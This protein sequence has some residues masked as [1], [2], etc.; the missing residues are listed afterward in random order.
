VEEI[1][2]GTPFELIAIDIMEAV[3]TLGEVIGVT[4]KED[5]IDQIFSRFCIGK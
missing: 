4:V 3:D 1:R 5:V 2:K